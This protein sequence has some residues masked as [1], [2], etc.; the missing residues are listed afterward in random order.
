MNNEYDLNEI[1]RTQPTTITPIPSN[2]NRIKSDN[3]L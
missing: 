3:H 1:N 2:K